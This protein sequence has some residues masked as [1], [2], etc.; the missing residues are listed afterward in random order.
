[1]KNLIVG[2]D[3]SSKTLDLCLKTNSG[4]EFLVIDNEISALKKLFR[5]FK[6]YDSVVI[7][8]EIQDVIIG[9]F[10]RFWKVLNLLFM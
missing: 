1:M 6:K 5:S 7:G 4:D 8:M 9:I 2:I 10:M 3:I